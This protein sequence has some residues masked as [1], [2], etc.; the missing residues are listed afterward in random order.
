MH[1][2]KKFL[3]IYHVFLSDDLSKEAFI[4]W[5]DNLGKR[6]RRKGGVNR[7]KSIEGRRAALDD[8]LEK[9]KAEYVPASTVR[10]EMLEWVENNRGRWRKKS[11]QTVKSGVDCFLDFADGREIDRGVVLSFFNWLVNNRHGKTHNKYLQRF[12]RIFRAL[13]K[14]EL[15]EGIEPVP[16]SSTP[17]KYFQ[18]HQIKRIKDYLLEAD[19]QLW[20]ACQFIYYCFIRPGEL[21]LLRVGDI[22]F[23]EWKICVRAAVSKNKKEQYV[24]I[25]TAFRPDLEFLK[26]R[27]PNEFIFFKDDYLKPL[28]RNNLLN[29]FRTALRALGFGLEYKLYS[30]KHTGAVATVKA[31]ASLK[32]VQIQL[33]HHSLEEVDKY[34]R[35]L[36]VNDLRDLESRFPCI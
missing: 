31:G 4:H 1:S 36:G 32:E 13:G 23:D 16:A 18:T 3:P 20:F 21:R 12:K 5:T 2:E 22:Y 33:R 17:A 8:L 14:P 10:D 11:Y 6:H 15:I 28:S 26:Y 19:P 9:L 30:W 25:P 27:S 24:T 7:I 34:L 29:R 35:Q